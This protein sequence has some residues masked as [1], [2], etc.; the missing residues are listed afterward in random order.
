MKGDFTTMVGE[1]KR[2]YKMIS[3]WNMTKKTEFSV[4]PEIL[5]S[6]EKI[7]IAQNESS[8]PDLPI[9]DPKTDKDV[10]LMDFLVDLIKNDDY[11]HPILHF[12]KAVMGFMEHLKEKQAKIEKG[13]KYSELG[14]D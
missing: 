9:K 7:V 12:D 1:E 4:K 2:A 8:Q 14:K 10:K 5:K 13:E 3:A 11:L 6:F